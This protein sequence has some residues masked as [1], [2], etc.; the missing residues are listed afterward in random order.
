MKEMKNQ[1]R[2]MSTVN[3]IEVQIYKIR[4]R[5][6]FIKSKEANGK[7]LVEDKSKTLLIFCNLFRVTFEAI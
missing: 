1:S 4:S 5:Y 7:T 6:F 3:K 2:S